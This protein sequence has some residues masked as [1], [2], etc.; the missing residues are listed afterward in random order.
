MTWKVALTQVQ[1]QVDGVRVL[2]AGQHGLALPPG[3][4]GLVVVVGEVVGAVLQ[5]RLAAVAQVAGLGDPGDAGLDA[6]L[7]G[8]GAAAV[9][10]HY[11]HVKSRVDKFG[12][13][14]LRPAALQALVHGGPGCVQEQQQGE[15]HGRPHP[16]GHSDLVHRG[17]HGLVAGKGRSQ[18]G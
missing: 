11:G 4:V 18:P 3:G 12:H 2:D 15:E 8:R 17:E 14:A 1:G 6:V 5:V 9:R 10:G 16:P 13:A 7:L